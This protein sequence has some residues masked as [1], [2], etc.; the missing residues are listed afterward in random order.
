MNRVSIQ[1]R[2]Y[3]LQARAESQQET[4]NRIVA[5]T[6][7]LHRQV[8]PA[9]T[10]IADIARIAGVQRLTVYNHFPTLS[11]LLG[12]CQGHFLTLHPPP[13]LAPGVGRP[14]PLGR[15]E[16]ALTELYGWYQANL[17]MERHIH[18]DRRVVPELDDL[19]AH[20]LD[21]ALDRAAGA[22]AQLLARSRSNIAA[23]RR[24]VRLGLDF[25]TW[26]LLTAHGDAN[27]ADVARLIRRTVDALGGASSRPA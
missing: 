22:Y 3:R 17:D 18:A 1:K 16:A 8:G 21:P 19:L 12:A 20:T 6:M 5:A 15:L 27:D 14:R 7:G 13:D 9:K 26:E 25:G 2:K 23:V 4:R 24:L 10:T 11:D